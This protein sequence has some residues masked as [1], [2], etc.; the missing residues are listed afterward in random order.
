MPH[1]KNHL[2]I[3]PVCSSKISSAFQ[4]GWTKGRG[5]L[6]CRQ[7]GRVPYLRKP[8]PEIF[9]VWTNKPQAQCLVPILSILGAAS[10]DLALLKREDQ[11]FLGSIGC[12]AHRT[13]ALLHEAF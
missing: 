1:E 9:A 8:L 6:L 7:R 11:F 3:N 12:P 2:T 10:P 4:R 5:D 13:G